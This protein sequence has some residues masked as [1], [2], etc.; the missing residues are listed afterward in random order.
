MGE[1]NCQVCGQPRPTR[2]TYCRLC[3]KILDRAD[4][5]RAFN[6]AARLQALDAS[7]NDGA[8]HCHFSGWVLTVTDDSSPFYLTW[9]HRTP[10]D[11][12]DI[13]VAAALINRVKAELTDEEFRTLVLGLAE[14][15]RDPSATVPMVSPRHW[16][17]TGPPI[18]ECVD[19][20]GA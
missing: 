17:S 2:A 11:E 15:F 14:R 4:D 18:V 19:P 9:D 7:F 20:T 6:R 1:A 16:R 8:F 13:V 3:K 12:C 10:G 5:R